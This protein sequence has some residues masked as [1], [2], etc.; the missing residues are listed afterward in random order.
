MN[1]LLQFSGTDFVDWYIY[2]Q[3]TV[4]HHIDPGDGDSKLLVYNSM[5]AQLIA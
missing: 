2:Q 4:I 1:E 3:H 5:L